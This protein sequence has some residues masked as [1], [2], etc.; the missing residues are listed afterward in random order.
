[1]DKNI[2]LMN[3][4]SCIYNEQECEYRSLKKCICNDLWERNMTNTLNVSCSKYTPEKPV[5][6][7]DY[8]KLWNDIESELMN[9]TV[10]HEI[11]GNKE[12]FATMRAT[13]T[14]MKYLENKQ[15]IDFK[16]DEE[17]Y[18]LTKERLETFNPAESIGR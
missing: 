9:S 17:D 16:E 10:Y 13:L 11:N 18:L 12:T 3:C 5:F 1:M 8:E 4:S 14:M 7:M 2:K 15:K 6:T